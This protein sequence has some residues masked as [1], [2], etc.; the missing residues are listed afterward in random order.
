MS[1]RKQLGLLRLEHHKKKDSET[2]KHGHHDLLLHR[3]KLS[4]SEKGDQIEDQDKAIEQQKESIHHGSSFVM[5]V[6]VCPT[7]ETCTLLLIV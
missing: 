3:H 6:V 4:S 7:L 5:F 1:N 2:V